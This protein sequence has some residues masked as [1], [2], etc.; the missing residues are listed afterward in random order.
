M[1]NFEGK[2]SLFSKEKQP[3][4]IFI[5]YWLNPLNSIPANVKV[6]E[7]TRTLKCPADPKKVVASDYKEISKIRNTTEKEDKYLYRVET[8][9]YNNWRNPSKNTV[10]PD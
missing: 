6:K 10:V 3:G 5:D 7:I 4:R 9:Q 1:K 2:A 8:A